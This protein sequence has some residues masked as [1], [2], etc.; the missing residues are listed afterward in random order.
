MPRV[1]WEAE[2]EIRGRGGIDPEMVVSAV[3]DALHREFG[4]SPGRMPLQV[5]VFSAEKP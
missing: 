2:D 1:L 4:D 3:V 5:I